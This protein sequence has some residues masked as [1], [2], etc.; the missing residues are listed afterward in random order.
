METGLQIKIIGYSNITHVH[1][2]ATWIY[3]CLKHEV[4]RANSVVA[5]DIHKK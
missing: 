1:M 4:S 5:M 2:H 3:L